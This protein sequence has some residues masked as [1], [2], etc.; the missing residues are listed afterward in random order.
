MGFNYSKN[1]AF[2]ID[3]ENLFFGKIHLPLNSY[4]GNR[5]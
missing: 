5:I 1:Y 4:V 2:I 3:R